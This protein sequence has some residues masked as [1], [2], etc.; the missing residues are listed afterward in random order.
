MTASHQNKSH[1]KY[2]Q[3]Q[4]LL[5]YVASS[6]L[7]S[8][9]LNNLYRATFISAVYSASKRVGTASATSEQRAEVSNPRLL[10]KTLF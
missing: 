4:S 10:C 5:P 8:L 2:G 3:I 1:L 9:V 7:L 6:Y